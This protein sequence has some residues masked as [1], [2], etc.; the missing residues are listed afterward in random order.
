[1]TAVFP[2]ASDAVVF[3]QTKDSVVRNWLG[4]G[5][6]PQFEAITTEGLLTGR[7]LEALVASRCPALPQVFSGLPSPFAGVIANASGDLK[8]IFIHKLCCASCC[9]PSD[10]LGTRAP[11]ACLQR[12]SSPLAAHP[13]LPPLT[14][15]R[16]RR[17]QPAR[18][19]QSGVAAG[20]E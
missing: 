19:S 10:A 9:A 18:G 16:F 4:A 12:P 17:P 3:S 5:D 6:P 13:P 11:A 2:S 7:Y 14:W 1:M 8:D 20:S 15:W